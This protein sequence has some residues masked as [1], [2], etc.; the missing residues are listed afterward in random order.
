[1]TLSSRNPFDLHPELRGDSHFG[2]LLDLHKEAVERTH[3]RAGAVPS[4]LRP[5]EFERYITDLIEITRHKGWADVFI[6]YDEAN[7]L[8]L[9]LSVDFL[10]WNVEAL[11]RAG[12]VTIY[13]ASPD[14]AE[15]FNPWAGREIRIGPFL[16]V[17]DMLR[18]LAKYYFGEISL[19]DDLPVAR[20]A[21]VRI[22][23]LS[24]GIPYLI[25]HLSGQSFFAANRDDARRVEER[26]VLTAHE[27]LSGKRPELFRD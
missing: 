13:S 11:N 18:L 17:E 15:K 2:D 14:M 10:T 3:T 7:R 24:R 21:I 27:E 1:M 5:D 19:R 4:E 8:P 26:H 9:E 20:E 16:S 12:V 23:E 6:F 25:Q 22:W